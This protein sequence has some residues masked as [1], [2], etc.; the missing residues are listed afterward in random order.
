MWRQSQAL[1]VSVDFPHWGSESILSFLPTP[2]LPLSKSNRFLSSRFLSLFSLISIPGLLTSLFCPKCDRVCRA[3]QCSSSMKLIGHRACSESSRFGLERRKS[4]FGLKVKPYSWTWFS[5]LDSTNT[6]SK[7]RYRQ[8]WFLLRPIFGLQ[9][10][11]S[12]LWLHMAF[13]CAHMF[14]VSLFLIIKDISLIGW[15]PSSSRSHLTLI[16]SLKSQHTH[17]REKTQEEP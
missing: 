14:L 12:L 9:M 6:W 13:L 5:E 3:G 4:H 11:V 7:I 1:H 8:L 2:S 17:N 16:T 10:A 15:G